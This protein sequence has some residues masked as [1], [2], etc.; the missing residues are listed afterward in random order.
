MAISREVVDLFLAELARYDLPTP[1]RLPDGA[2]RLE[3][4][5]L[6]LVIN[7]ENLSRDFAEDHDPAR[8]THFVRQIL[9][10]C[11]TAAAWLSCPAMPMR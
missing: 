11:T 2:F 1:E 10:H 4:G 3:I 5:E 7:L 6:R 9:V 8:V